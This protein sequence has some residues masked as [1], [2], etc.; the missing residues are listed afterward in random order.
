MPGS[1][2]FFHSAAESLLTE[3]D[4]LDDLSGDADGVLHLKRV[5]SCV[6]DIGVTDDE[7]CVFSIAVYL[8]AVQ[9]VLEFDT[10]KEPRADRLWLGFNGNVEVNWFST[11]HM[12]NLLRNT[13][14]INLGHD[15]NAQK[16]QIKKLEADLM[17]T[18]TL[19][20]VLKRSRQLFHLN[21]LQRKECGEKHKIPYF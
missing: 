14:H 7:M 19:R 10:S 21:L 18:F 4:D 3:D 17:I 15:W 11:V 6:V 20:G 8:D 1:T 5:V 2:R 13:G 12:D 16:R 9:A